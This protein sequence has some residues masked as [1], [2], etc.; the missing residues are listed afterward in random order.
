MIV[1]LDHQPD[2]SAFAVT[3]V[4][5]SAGYTQPYNKDK[6]GSRFRILLDTQVALMNSAPTVTV[7]VKPFHFKKKLNFTTFYVG[8]AGT[9]ADLLKNNVS[10]LMISSQAN[11]G[12]TADF[13]LCYKDL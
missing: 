1:V 5:E 8:N 9:V 7:D 13:Q 11:V 12:V 6:V 4:L 10:V 2:G 3:D